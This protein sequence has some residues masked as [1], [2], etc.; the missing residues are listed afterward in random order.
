MIAQKKDKYDLHGLTKEI[1]I[2]TILLKMV[3]DEFMSQF[4]VYY[5]QIFKFKF[6]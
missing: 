6:F 3:M 1:N 5:I 2:S 4:L